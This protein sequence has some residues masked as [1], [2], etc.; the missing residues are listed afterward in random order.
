VSYI[1]KTPE[2]RLEL[3]GSDFEAIVSK[4]HV[5]VSIFDRISYALD[6]MPYDLASEEI[7]YAVVKPSSE[8]EV[9]E[10]LK[11]ANKHKIPVWAYGSGAAL[12]GATRPKCKCIVLSTSRRKMLKYII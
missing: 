8:E 1:D 11:Y 7:P 12:H 3:L 6:P 9:S 10:I 5:S 4:D 2:I